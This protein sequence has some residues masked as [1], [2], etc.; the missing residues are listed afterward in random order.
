[1]GVDTLI[2]SEIRMEIRTVQIPPS[3]IPEIRPGLESL[4][5]G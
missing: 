3:K 4:G 1:M 5:K 2:S